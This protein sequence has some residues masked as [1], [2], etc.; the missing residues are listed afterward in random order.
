MTDPGRLGQWRACLGSSTGLC[1]RVRVT[2]STLRSSQVLSLIKLNPIEIRF[3]YH[4]STEITRTNV[5]AAHS[6]SSGSS[7]GCHD[8]FFIVGLLFHVDRNFSSRKGSSWTRRECSTS[9]YI[10][11]FPLDRSK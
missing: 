3:G 5:L 1:S 7:P 9:A 10:L 6:F 4:I 2:T 8:L 11:F